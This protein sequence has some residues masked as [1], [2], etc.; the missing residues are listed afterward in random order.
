[1]IGFMGCYAA[2]NGLKQA[3]HIVRSQP[4]AKVLLVNLELCTLHLQETQELEQVLSFLVFGD[5][6]AASLISAE[7]K[8]FGM[9]S[10]R[11]VL[12][13]ET[14]GLITWRIGGAGFDMFLS[15]QVPGAIGAGLATAGGEALGELLPHEISL[16]G[17]HPGGKS[18][19]DAVERGL[20]LAPDALAA[21]RQTLECFGNMSSATVMFVLE[22]LLQT[23]RPGQRG[24]AM[25]FGPGLTAETMLFHAA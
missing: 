1:M 2:I 22:R 4:E 18:V 17:V 23:A 24:C 20:G 19:L 14:R 21:S 7:P 25:S 10:F 6:C 3:R 8:G 15:G 13:P 12:L 16:W 11:A 5:G 9:D